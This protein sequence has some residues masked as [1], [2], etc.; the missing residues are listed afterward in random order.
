LLEVRGELEAF[1]L[2]NLKKNKMNREIMEIFKEADSL[3]GL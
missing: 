2:N 3:K 1:E